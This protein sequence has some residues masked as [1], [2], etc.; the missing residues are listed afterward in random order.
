VSHGVADWLL[1]SSRPPSIRACGSPAHGSPTLFTASIQRGRRRRP[2]GRGGAI[3]PLRSI[4][5]RRFGD[6]RATAHHPNRRSRRWRI[7]TKIASR[8][9]A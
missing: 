1:V 2:E 8:F 5:P 4:S 6:W 9:I 3:V 7:A